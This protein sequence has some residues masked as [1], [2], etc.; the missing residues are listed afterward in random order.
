MDP[1]EFEKL[2]A[3]VWEAKGYDT[4]VRDQTGD[5]G[6]DVEAS[7][8]DSQAVIQ[9]KRYSDDNTIGSQ[10]VREYATLYQQT[11]ADDVVIVSSGYF[12]NPARELATDLDVSLVNGDDI[13]QLIQSIE[14]E[15]QPNKQTTEKQSSK[16]GLAYAIKYTLLL[17]FPIGIGGAIADFARTEYIFELFSSLL[18]LNITLTPFVKYY[19][20]N[21]RDALFKPKYDDP[22]AKHAASMQAYEKIENLWTYLIFILI[23]DLFITGI[24][25]KSEYSRTFAIVLLFSITAYNIIFA[26][27]IWRDKQ[28]INDLLGSPEAQIIWNETTAIP[29]SIVKKL[30]PTIF[31]RLTKSFVFILILNFI[32]FG[33][34][35]LFYRSNRRGFNKSLS[36]RYQR[37]ED[38][39]DSS[40]IQESPEIT[41]KDQ[42]TSDYD[43][44]NISV[45]QVVRDL[46]S[47]NGQTRLEASKKANQMA[48]NS[49]DIIGDLIKEMIEVLATNHNTD[50]VVR[51]DISIV[52]F[53][54]SRQNPE[55]IRPYIKDIKDLCDDNNQTVSG[56][57][58]GVLAVVSKEY[59]EDVREFLHDFREEL[60]SNHTK[61]RGNVLMLM[62]G[63]AEEYPADVVPLLEDIQLL[64]ED[65]NPQIRRNATALMV[66]IA[67]EFPSAIIPILSKIQ[68]LMTDENPVVR[69][70]ACGIIAYISVDYGGDLR[71]LAELVQPLVDDNNREV[72]E[73][74]EMAIESINYS[75][76]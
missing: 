58:I 16:E 30:E 18:A 41:N 64:L 60:Y 29:K 63:I 7:K 20:Y 38:F 44:D 56:Q 55:Y 50:N 4:T 34:W 61:K 66:D 51:E 27:Y 24:I 28:Q 1:F 33:V 35:P 14:I 13:I 36:S 53:E 10:K 52:I 47:E 39:P 37:I 32:S 67:V 23:F 73:T 43:T 68:P 19:G 26:Y 75:S 65:A 57:T 3:A 74:A 46:S 9:V 22:V 11:D 5:K 54:L 21:Y 72:R 2:V 8:G 76:N 6:I 49:P 25:I 40:N 48:V 15:E 45:E 31:G 70:N 42:K 62:E 17:C 69:K 71:S 12:T 59:P